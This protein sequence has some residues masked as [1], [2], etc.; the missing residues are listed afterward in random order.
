MGGKTTMLFLNL[1]FVLSVLF[2][3]L[4]SHACVPGDFQRTL[5]TIG[6]LNTSLADN[7]SPP[8]DFGIGAGGTQVYEPKDNTSPL[9][10]YKSF[11]N[12]K[13]PQDKEKW[14]NVFFFYDLAKELN[15]TTPVEPKIVYSC[16]NNK[17][18]NEGK[19][20]IGIPFSPFYKLFKQKYPLLMETHP[21]CKSA[22]YDFE[23]SECG[24]KKEY[25]SFVYKFLSDFSENGHLGRYVA[26][27]HLLGLGDPNIDNVGLCYNKNLC[28][29]DVDHFGEMA[30]DTVFSQKTHDQQLGTRNLVGFIPHLKFKDPFNGNRVAYAQTSDPNLIKRWL[31]KFLAKKALRDRGEYIQDDNDLKLKNF[32]LDEETVRMIEAIHFDNV[33]NLD[34]YYDF[35]SRFGIN[36]GLFPNYADLQ[37]PLPVNKSALRN[38]IQEIVEIDPDLIRNTVKATCEKLQIINEHAPNNQMGPDDCGKSI[39]ENILAHQQS[40]KELLKNTE[41][42]RSLVPVIQAGVAIALIKV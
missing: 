36:M 9:L 42:V 10:F 29:I 8:K 12:L 16:E 25:D 40:F 15:F 6:K 35:I 31:H 30:G 34:G 22:K 23:F 13:R 37:T 18:S 38:T 2:Y 26:Y 3:S 24:L 27:F 4:H 7:Y 14:F 32:V 11:I 33:L 19:L 39:S 41:E 28:I 17:F 20:T 5:D 21:N 1:F